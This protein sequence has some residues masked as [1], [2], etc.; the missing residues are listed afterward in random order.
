M[1]T[2]I[3]GRYPSLAKRKLLQYVVAAGSKAYGGSNP[4]L[5]KTGINASVPVVVVS[6]FVL[7]T[8]RRGYGH[9]LCGHK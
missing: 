4:P 2:T 1:T 7:L 9:F 5:P 6:L 8:D 3:Q